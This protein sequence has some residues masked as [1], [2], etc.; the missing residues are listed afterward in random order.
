MYPRIL[1]IQ[2]VMMLLACNSSLLLGRSLNN[3][4]IIWI[5]IFGA[6]AAFLVVDRMKL[7]ELSG[8]MANLVC[9]LVLFYTM[10]DFIGGGSVTKLVSVANLLAYLLAVLLFQKKTPRLC[11]QIMVLSLL[12]VVV[13]AI[14]NL[15]FEDGWLFIIYFAVVTVAFMLQNDFQLWT[16]IHQANHRSREPL[17]QRQRAISRV[18]TAASIPAIIV[19]TLPAGTPST[20][21]RWLLLPWVGGSLLF[22]F[23]LFHSLPHTRQDSGNPTAQR[24]MGTGKSWQA[25]L[26]E[27]GIVPRSN[28]LQFRA[29]FFD[30]QT[31][32]KVV[33]NSYP[34]FRGMA[35]S[36]LILDNG[37]TSWEAPY[38]HVFDF[39]SYHRQ[40]GFPLSL[41]SSNNVRPVGLEIIME[42]VT[43]PLLFA[44][45]PAYRKQGAEFVP[46]FCRDLSAL[47]RRRSKFTNGLTSFHYQLTT[48]IDRVNRPL[49]GWPY[50]SYFKEKST[51][52]PMQ[53][54]SPEHRMLT[55]M[56]PSRYPELT[57]V[58]RLARQQNPTATRSELCQRLVEHFSSR[59][60]YDYTVDY[61]EVDRDRTLDPVEDF[62][63][64]HRTGH[65]A[66]Y[67]SALTLML[68]SLDIPARYVVGFH[69]SDF[70]QLAECYIVHGRQAHAW[71]EAYLPPEA[72]SEE[73]MERGIAGPGGAWLTLDPTPPVQMESSNEA[74]DLARSIWQDY[75]ISPDHNK[76]RYHGGGPLEKASLA[77]SR[78]R[79]VLDSIFRFAQSSRLFQISLLAG[80]LLLI[81]YY[82]LRT[83]SLAPTARRSIPQANPVRRWTGKFVGVFSRDL[84]RRIS[85]QPEGAPTIPFYRQC[86]MLL[87]K[88]WGLERQP[89][90]TQREFA[91]QAGSVILQKVDDEALKSGIADL[92]P[93]VTDAFYQAR[94]ANTPLD[95]EVI[96]GLENQMRD[97]EHQL[98]KRHR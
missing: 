33:L 46:E 13:A 11:W 4:E 80:V 90:Q 12:Q 63:R 75:V 58:A 78:T 85:G 96:A 50:R 6:V 70:N 5:S 22:A 93:Q 52:Y 10:K 17:G 79:Q 89:S 59:N 42:P 77:D 56:D 65:C 60:G 27:Q 24:F 7:A 92:L 61:R 97:M 55:E 41:V 36:K 30:L 16:R 48:V 35:M 84:G 66:M 57:R 44:M 91:R 9:L 94:F 23:L 76:Q 26:D 87:K 3:P 71:V 69:G 98:K 37:K 43:D 31:G 88:Y 54:D 74:I 45:M 86:E 83:Q 64:N 51:S 1:S 14:F 73:M 28:A 38:D 53:V 49:P 47:T 19:S 34:Y 8:W 25:N 40:S 39:S 29:R 81:G 2:V 15:N 21:S 20:T 67:A 68:R 72:C 62:V 95:R 82:S 18:A 32:E